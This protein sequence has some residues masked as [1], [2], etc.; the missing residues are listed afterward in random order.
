VKVE[1]DPSL[2]DKTYDNKEFA[3]VIE[4]LRESVKKDPQKWPGSAKT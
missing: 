4:R 3:L 2:L 1:K